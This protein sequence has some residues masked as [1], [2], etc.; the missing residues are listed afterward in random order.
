[1]VRHHPIDRDA[2]LEPA[3]VPD[4]RRPGRRDNVSPTLIPLLREDS[5]D[6]LRDHLIDSEPDQLRPIRAIIFWVLLFGVLW[7]ILLWWVFR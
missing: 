6:H 1:M 3:A 2:E 4:R 5:L 7:A